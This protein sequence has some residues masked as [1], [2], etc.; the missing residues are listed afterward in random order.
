MDS[1]N[2]IGADNQQETNFAAL[3]PGWVVGFTDGEGC[4]SVSLHRNALG[5][6]TGGWQIQPTFQVPQHSDHDD[7]LQALKAFF[8]RGNVRS[9]GAGSLVNVFVAHS[10]VQLVERVIPFFK[11]HELRVKAR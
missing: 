2:P 4:F 7:V 10:T 6:K 5:V 8:Q 9:K 3:D 11:Q 1:E